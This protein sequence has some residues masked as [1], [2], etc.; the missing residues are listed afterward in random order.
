VVVVDVGE[1]LPV[2]VAHDEARALVIDG[3][4]GREVARVAF[5][6]HHAVCWTVCIVLN[7]ALLTGKPVDACIDRR[8]EVMRQ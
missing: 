1:G 4:R 3:P 8:V 2:V 5:A 7:S 6:I